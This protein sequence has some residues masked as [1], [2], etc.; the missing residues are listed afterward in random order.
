MADPTADIKATLTKKL[1]PLP[2]WAWV[3]IGAAVGFWYLKMH[4]GSA[5]ATATNGMPVSAGGLLGTGGGGAIDSGLNP[6]VPPPA[7]GGGSVPPPPPANT[8]Q[9][10]QYIPSVFAGGG[11]QFANGLPFQNW[12]YNGIVMA[13]V[14]DPA[15]AQWRQDISRQLGSYF[16]NSGWQPGQPLPSFYGMGSRLAGVVG[17]YSNY[18]PASALPAAGTNVSGGQPFAYEVLNGVPQ[19]GRYVN[20]S[21]VPV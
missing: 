1:G 12:D 18:N 8:T 3:G 2:T 10:P 11:N 4:K 5:A 20:G 7:G 14:G 17:G 19:Y 13:Q 6:Q 9:T 21:V 16:A 15:A